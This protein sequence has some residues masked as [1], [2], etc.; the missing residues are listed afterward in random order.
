MENRMIRLI[1]LPVLALLVLVMSLLT[2]KGMFSAEAPSQRGLSISKNGRYFL[3]DGKPFLWLGDSAW[4]LFSLYTKDEITYYLEHRKQQG[5]NVVQ[6]M[7]PFNGGPGLKTAGTDVEG[8]LPFHDWDPQ[9]PNEN[10]FKKVDWVVMEAEQKG[11]V[12][13]VLA[14]GGSGGSFVRVKKVFTRENAKGY[15]EW[16]G[17]RYKDATNIIWMNGFD[18]APWSFQEVAEEFAEGLRSTDK[19][20]HLV[21]YAPAGGFS[22]SYFQDAK[23][24]S[25]NHIQTW[26]DYWRAP[27]F[28]LSDYCQLPVKP[29]VMA[30]GAYEAGPEY[31]SRPITPHVVRKE[32]YWSYLSG[33]FHTYG[34]NDIWR[35]NF[36]WR[37]SLD[38]PGAKQMTILKKLLE[39]CKWWQLVPDQSLFVQNASSDKTFNSASRSTDSD[40]AI[41][42]LSSR[43]SV[44]ID[45]RRVAR[46]DRVTVT[47]M[48][49]ATGATKDL[50]DFPSH[51]TQTIET[52]ADSEDAVL[53]LDAKVASR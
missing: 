35:K 26:S 39:T 52:P 45:L 2:E 20:T 14:M 53:L 6:V 11:I 10:Y 22:S 51:S 3:Q 8:N 16:L 9:R 13:Y 5:F 18:L 47:F 48:N 27:A 24:V 1:K 15:G 42:Y 25:F 36:S 44:P 41:V 28:V 50:G 43:T 21:S 38:S 19:G 40:F 37:E 46:T 49:P 31:P 4:S 17:R 34:H 32:A 23:W 29:V 7:I 33:G 12:L 30:E